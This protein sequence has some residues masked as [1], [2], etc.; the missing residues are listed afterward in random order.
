MSA[1]ASASLHRA[2]L[3]RLQEVTLTTEPDVWGWPVLGAPP[4]YVRVE[5]VGL[6]PVKGLKKLGLAPIGAAPPA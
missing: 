4:T 2:L 1:A 3:F 5:G 6:V